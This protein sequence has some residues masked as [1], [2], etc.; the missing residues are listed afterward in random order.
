M[1]KAKRILALL[2][3]CGLLFG[4]GAATTA[5][6]TDVCPVCQSCDDSCV[7]GDCYEVCACEAQDPA[8]D[9]EET[10]EYVLTDSFQAL[11][12]WIGENFGEQIADVCTKIITKVGLFFAKMGIKLVFKTVVKSAIKGMF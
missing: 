2:L 12:D 5:S 6:A 3:V 8:E 11:L 10:E 7:P 4:V 9:A 1:K